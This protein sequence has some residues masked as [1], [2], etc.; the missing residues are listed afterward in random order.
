MGL[1]MERPLSPPD[2][3][4]PI[5]A[6]LCAVLED[7]F[8]QVAASCPNVVHLEVLEQGLH[9]EPNRLRQ[10]VQAAIDRVEEQ[11]AVEAIVL[12]YG[13]CSRGTE[14]VT[15]RRAKLVVPRAHDCI[16][17]LLGS[18]ERY[19]GYVAKN[20]GTYWYSPGWN[21]HHVPPG[22][23]R[24]EKLR[25]EYA[26]KYG[27]DNAD[28][29]MESEQAW[30]KTYSRATFVEMGVAVKQEDIE[31]TKR[32]AEYLGWSFDHQRGDAKL[33]HDLLAGNWDDERFLVLEPGD[34]LKMTADGRVIEKAGVGDAS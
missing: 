18:K 25:A 9:N 33:L 3:T 31:F 17:L 1:P 14:G 15:T 11:H 20:P 8:K 4:V 24:Y 19:A 6:I 7:E 12:G 10:E 28:F 27:E 21:R 22:P 23:E 2:S 29:L 5:A 16:T 26:E 13:L 30:F 32:C 34:A